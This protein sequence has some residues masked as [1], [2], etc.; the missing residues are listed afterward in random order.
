MNKV[1]ILWKEWPLLEYQIIAIY[2]N[3]EKAIEKVD[4]LNILSREAKE[5]IDYY[6][7]E[8]ELDNDKW[9]N[10]EEKYL[11]KENKKNKVD[12]EEN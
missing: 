1:Y 8:Y 12:R 5:T 6:I 3:K 2:T 11:K 4:K 7:T 10:I 9:C